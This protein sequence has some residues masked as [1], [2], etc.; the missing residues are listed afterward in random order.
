MKKI[1]WKTQANYSS[2]NIGNIRL[3]CWRIDSVRGKKIWTTN[4][5]LNYVASSNRHGPNRH[6]LVAAKNDALILAEELLTDYYTS[7]VREIECY[8]EYLKDL[9]VKVME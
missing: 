3:W 1:I 2:A 5:S 4:V 8:D 6:S 7:I 9:R